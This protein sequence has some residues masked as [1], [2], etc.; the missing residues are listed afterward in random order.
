EEAHVS[1]TWVEGERRR[2]RASPGSIGTFLPLRGRT[3]IFRLPERAGTSC[4]I[5]DVEP[6]LHRFSRS[7]Q[8]LRSPASDATGPPE[9]CMLPRRPKSIRRAA[10]GVARGSGRLT[11]QGR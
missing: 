2:A 9:R 4:N 5:G 3:A 7:Y 6:R 1:V 10:F 11:R 8:A